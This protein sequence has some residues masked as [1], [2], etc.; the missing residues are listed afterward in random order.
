VP[1]AYTS[2]QRSARSALL[3]R[4][5]AA[6]PKGI[7][8]KLDNQGLTWIR[9]TGTSRQPENR[10]PQQIL[11]VN[12]KFSIPRADLEAAWMGAAQ[13][14]ADTPGLQWKVWLM[15]EAENEAGGI[16]L[17]DSK[18]SAHSYMSGPI[19]AA[20]KASPAITDISAKLFDVLEEHT[21][22]TRGPLGAVAAPA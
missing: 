6:R 19:V 11:Q 14:I 18:Q 16:Y 7:S 5:V 20:L 21:A 13:P 22:V 12:L 3:Q 9:A 10:M 8:K 1:C 2:A 15:N 4:A 17:F